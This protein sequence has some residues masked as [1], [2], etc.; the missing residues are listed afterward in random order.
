MTTPIPVPLAPLPVAPPPPVAPVPLAPPAMPVKPASPVMAPD[1][2]AWQTPRPAV[3]QPVAQRSPGGFDDI[4][5][6]IGS[7]GLSFPLSGLGAMV[8][9][10]AANP[11]LG[12]TL[13]V[14]GGSLLGVLIA[15]HEVWS[16][17]RP[18]ANPPVRWGMVKGAM[19]PAGLTLAGAGL[20]A[21]L[22]GPAGGVAV[23]ATI[24][25]GL[26]WLWILGSVIRAR[27]ERIPP[28]V[29]GPTHPDNMTPPPAP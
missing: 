13:A 1:Q 16:G 19:I 11:V 9:V 10:W 24:G 2:V 4:V 12:A 18:G 20:G 25:V 26:P 14:V 8:G 15:G 5:A 28:P 21:M 7:F 23:G 27:F 3:Q 17:S 22:A 29:D 6:V